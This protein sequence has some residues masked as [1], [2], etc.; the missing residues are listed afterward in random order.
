MFRQCLSAAVRPCS[1]RSPCSKW[2]RRTRNAPSSRARGTHNVRTDRRRTD[3]QMTTT[4]TG[5]KTDGRTARKDKHG[6]AH[7]QGAPTFMLKEKQTNNDHS[8]RVFGGARGRNNS[9]SA[10]S[11][12]ALEGGGKGHLNVDILWE[13]K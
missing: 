5:Q 12:V 9:V 1:F 7:S 13:H 3:G 11:L 6:H 2:A 10:I 8:T 4:R